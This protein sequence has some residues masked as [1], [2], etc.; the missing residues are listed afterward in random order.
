[1]LSNPL[2]PP[3]E[4]PNINF[5]PGNGVRP[6]MEPAVHF[7]ANA[8]LAIPL[9]LGTTDEEVRPDIERTSSGASTDE[10]HDMSDG[11]AAL[12]MTFSHAEQL[13]AEMDQ[14]DADLMGPDN[15]AGLY[16]DTQFPVHGGDGDTFQ[17]DD[18]N[19]PDYYSH[20]SPDTYDTLD[21]TMDEMLGA[22]VSLGMPNN[23]SLP[24]AMS[25]VSLQ[26]QHLQEDGLLHMDQMDQ[27]DQ[28]HVEVELPGHNHAASA[29]QTHS[30]TPFPLSSLLPLTPA[31]MEVLETLSVPLDSSLG[32]VA[33]ALDTP[34][35]WSTG[36]TPSSAAGVLVSTGNQNPLPHCPFSDPV[37]DAGSDAD[38]SEVDDAHYNLSFGDFLYNWARSRPQQEEWNKRARVPNLPAV[39]RQRSMENLD[40]VRR[41]DL[42]G[43]LCDIQRVNWTQL[44]VSRNEA[45][46]KR[47]RDYKNYINVRENAWAQSHVCCS[48][49]RIF[50]CKLAYS[51]SRVSME[52][53]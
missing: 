30:T 49:S 11:G 29:A 45:K 6:A 5:E 36:A 33:G 20:D 41:C 23:T 8:R 24:T 39:H 16:M 13:N 25:A 12:A 4:D 37:W 48:P 19:T 27:A 35:L 26:L 50:S 18:S 44:G 2:T 15:L 14:L 17:Y 21:E 43:E 38:Q 9:T 1:M 31:H 46:D 32:Q 10:D 53:N 28:A 47:R 3:Y 51:C 34:H 7:L 40:P 22:E 52:S 42:Q